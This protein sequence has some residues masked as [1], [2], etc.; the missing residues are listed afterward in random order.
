MMG[1]MDES[2]L[3]GPALTRLQ[4]AQLTYA[5]VGAT[6]GVLPAG[7]HHVRRQAVVGAGTERFEQAA[8]TLMGWG[9]QRGAGLRV[10]PSAATAAVGVVA[11]Q[12]LGIGRLSLAAPVR[13]VYVIDEPRRRGYAYGTLPGHAERGEEAFVVEIDNTDRVL[14]TVTAFSTPGSVLT[15][16]GGPVAR[17]GQ[18]W[19]AARYLRSV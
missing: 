19:M 14:L 10:R 15:R 13:V 7:Y 6:R 18:A 17:L 5:D 8:R 2:L 3:S 1:R 9:M 16:L 4:T 12:R 11:D